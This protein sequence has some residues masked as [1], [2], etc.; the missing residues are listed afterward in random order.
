M[1]AIRQAPIEPGFEI[2]PVLVL[3]PP[4]IREPRGSV[5]PKFAEG[6]SKCQGLA[7]AFQEAAQTLGC[8][9]FDTG[10]VIAASD[11]DG[12][13]LDAAAHRILGEALVSLVTEI[14]RGR[15]ART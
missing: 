1:E 5:A 7:G 4:P 8:A 12:V 3:A 15:P 13:H 10:Q 2:P 14:L 11:T 9:F 6:D